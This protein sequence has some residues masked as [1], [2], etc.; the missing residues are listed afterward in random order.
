[1]SGS[2]CH[3]VEFS[4]CKVGKVVIVVVVVGFSGCQVRAV[5]VGGFGNGRDEGWGG[6]LALSPTL[7]LL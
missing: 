5:K 6:K 7:V 1:M 3:V 2:G 4:R